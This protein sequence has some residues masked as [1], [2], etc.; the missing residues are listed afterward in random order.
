MQLG[1]NILV[2]DDDS[3][4]RVGLEAVLTERGHSVSEAADT[5][6]AIDSLRRQRFDLVLLDVTL[7]DGNGLKVAEFLR[8]KMSN[9]KVIVITGTPGLEHALKSAAIGVHDY[10]AKPFTVQ[11]LL[12]SID[13]ALNSRTEKRIS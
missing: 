7:P 2:V 11:Y 5:H 13:H 12:G 3:D 4:L 1:A 6:A 9:T 8:M 10:I